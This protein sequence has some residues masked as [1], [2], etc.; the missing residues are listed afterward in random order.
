MSPKCDFSSASSPR[1]PWCW[2]VWRSFEICRAG[3][4]HHVDTA[5]PAQGQR[6]ASWPAPDPVCLLQQREPPL[7]DRWIVPLPSPSREVSGDG[8]E[9]RWRRP[10]EIV[11]EFLFPGQ[12]WEFL[13]TLVGG[14]SPTILPPEHVVACTSPECARF[15]QVTI[16]GKGGMGGLGMSSGGSL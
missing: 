4:L 10:A 13:P 15:D 1:Q 6:G 8:S 16:L 7:S 12:N 14:A 2:L 11:L 5:S 9:C 3:G